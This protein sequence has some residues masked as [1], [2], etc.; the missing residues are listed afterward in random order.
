YAELVEEFGDPA[1]E[2]T[3][4]V[5]TTEQKAALGR[6]TASAIAATE[7]AGEPIT[8][9]L[10]EAPGNGAAVGGVKVVTESAW[11]AA[12]PS[13]TEDVYKIYAESFRGSEH[14]RRVQAEAKVI[15]DAAL[16]PQGA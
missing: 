10:S 15:V 6:L 2:R 1:Y 8:A 4:A 5:A 14:L 13:G 9:K 3:D 12:R 7:L 16:A 11:F